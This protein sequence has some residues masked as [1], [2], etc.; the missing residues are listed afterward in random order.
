MARG[1]GQRIT[2][3]G[4]KE[5]TCKAS[6]GRRGSRQGG[7][8]T[9][10]QH[11]GSAATSPRC[12]E[13]MRESSNTPLTHCHPLERTR[14]GDGTTARRAGGGRRTSTHMSRATQRAVCRGTPGMGHRLIVAR[15][16]AR[17]QWTDTR[18]SI[19]H[20]HAGICWSGPRGEGRASVQQ[21]ADGES[22]TRGDACSSGDGERHNHLLGPRGQDP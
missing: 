19:A 15:S 22:R 8:A 1:G 11:A 16:Q 12:A 3:M 14:D 17:G 5:A 6:S 21:G 20:A 2:R 13:R 9:H 4:S 10:V 18:P 7:D